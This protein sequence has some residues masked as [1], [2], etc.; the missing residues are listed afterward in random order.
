MKNNRNSSGYLIN[1]NSLA[2]IKKSESA[3]FVYLGISCLLVNNNQNYMETSNSSIRWKTW[4]EKGRPEW[5]PRPNFDIYIFEIK[6]KILAEIHNLDIK[7]ACLENDIPVKKVNHNTDIFSEFI[8]HNFSNSIFDDTFPSELKKCRSGSSLS[9]SRFQLNL[10]LMVLTTSLSESWRVFF[11]I[12]SKEQKLI[13]S[14]AVILKLDMEFHRGRFWVP[15][16]LISISATYLLT[17]SNAISRV[18]Q[19]ITHHIILVLI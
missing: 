4:S 6:H 3:F 5:C 16:F 19:T 1:R 10:L 18:M 12:D 9:N 11:P 15:Y 14:L 8:F 17:K 13:M 2:A 7:K